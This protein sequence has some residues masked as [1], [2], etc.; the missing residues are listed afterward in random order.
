MLDGNKRMIGAKCASEAN[1][2]IMNGFV[3]YFNDVFFAW[4]F[5]WNNDQ[6]LLN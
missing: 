1:T 3:V 2:P 6:R 4:Q 5:P